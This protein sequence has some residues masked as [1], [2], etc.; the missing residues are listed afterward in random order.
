LSSD[1]ASFTQQ[2]RCDVENDVSRPPCTLKPKKILTDV[3]KYRNIKTFPNKPMFF[4]SP[5]VVS[6]PSSSVHQIPWSVSI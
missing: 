4:S 1:V 2:K 3:K 6:K 5:L